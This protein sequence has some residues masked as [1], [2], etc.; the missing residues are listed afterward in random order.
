MKSPVNITNK[1]RIINS[2]VRL[3]ETYGYS[4]VT[5][6]KI[7]YESG[8]SKG[9][10][11]HNFKSKDELLYTIHDFMITY[12][13]E[14]QQEAIHKCDS[15]KDT[16]AEIIRSFVLLFRT[17]RSHL[18]IFNEE[19]LHLSKEYYQKIEEKRDLYKN[20]MYQVI[21]DGVKKGEFRADLNVQII[22]MAIFGMLNWIYKWY[23]PSGDFSL[24]EISEIY[25]DFILQSML[26]IAK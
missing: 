13:L 20:R 11:Y 18:T 25:S 16:L 9:G 6:D 17:Y 4:N 10:F 8:T 3:F 2:A 5:V 22:T 1:D 7:V 21:D 24:E 12:A 23:K 19:T 15:S 14:K 26:S